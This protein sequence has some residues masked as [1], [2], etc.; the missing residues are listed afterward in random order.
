L[1][2]SKESFDVVGCR[3]FLRQVIQDRWCADLSEEIFQARHLI[4]RQPTQMA[5]P[6]LEWF[7]KESENSWSL[8][9]SVLKGRR[10]AKAG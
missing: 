5:V 2:G 6:L 4:E 8:N 1:D 9:M 10:Q 7:C 3:G